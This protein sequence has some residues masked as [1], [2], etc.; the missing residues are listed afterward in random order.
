MGKLIFRNVKIYPPPFIAPKLWAKLGQKVRLWGAK[1]KRN[2]FFL[3]AIFPLAL[4]PKIRLWGA[5][6]RGGVFS[7]IPLGL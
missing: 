5:H 3:G 2:N 4:G 7:M 1:E 6:R